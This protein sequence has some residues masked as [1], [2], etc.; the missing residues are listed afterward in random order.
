[1]IWDIIFVDHL[2]L[3]LH[4]LLALVIRMYGQMGMS[5][6]VIYGALGKAHCDMR[7]EDTGDVLSCTW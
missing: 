4:N 5:P 3:S 1:M 2:V 6:G 7:F